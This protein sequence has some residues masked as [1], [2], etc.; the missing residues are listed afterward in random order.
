MIL[1]AGRCGFDDRVRREQRRTRSRS[2]ARG[3]CPA[4]GG[5][6]PSTA[7]PRAAAS[8][9]SVVHASSQS[10][11]STRCNVCHC[12]IEHRGGPSRHGFVISSGSSRGSRFGQLERVARGLLE[13]T[14]ERN[15]T[16]KKTT[17]RRLVLRRDIVKILSVDLRY[18]RGGTDEADDTITFLTI[19]ESCIFRSCH[20]DCPDCWTGG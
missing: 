14:Q 15:T 1:S 13:S 7:A 3:R 17:S 19:T 6:P 8:T 18:A 5:T 2:R 10:L 11:P 4:R 16:M 9:A 12:E 20:S